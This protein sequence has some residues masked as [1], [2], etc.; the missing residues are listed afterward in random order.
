VLL[1][2]DV[3]VFTVVGLGFVLLATKPDLIAVAPD[4]D[5]LKDA[6]EYINSHAKLFV[7]VVFA[8]VAAIAPSVTR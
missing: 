7:G 8:A 4:A 2:L 1:L 3:I 6:P 5:A